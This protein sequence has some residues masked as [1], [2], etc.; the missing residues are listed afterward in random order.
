MDKKEMKYLNRSQENTRTKR[1]KEDKMNRVL[2]YLIALV[3]ALIVISL[4]IIF[5]MQD[6]DEVVEEVQTEETSSETENESSS[7]VDETEETTKE[8]SEPSNVDEPEVQEEETL[9][10]NPQSNVVNASDNPLVDE[11]WTSETWQ[12]YAT[13]QT[14]EH[15]STFDTNDIDY[16]EKLGAIFS[17]VPINEQEAIIWSVKNNGNAQSAIAVI[18][19]NDKVQKYRVAIEWVEQQGWKPI[20]VEVLNTLDGTY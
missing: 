12:P 4:F 6:D 8:P 14:G 7:V 11:V 20:Q 5:T 19:S 13:A 9:E 17:V 2:N 3:S 1:R 18:S 16:Q 15:R 10:N